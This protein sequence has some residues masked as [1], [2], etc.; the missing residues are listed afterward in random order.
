MSYP[1]KMLNPLK[2]ATSVVA[3]V[4]GAFLFISS[5]VAQNAQELE[6]FCKQGNMQ[7]CNNLYSS[8]QQACLNGNSNACEYAANM[9]RSFG[10]GEPQYPGAVQSPTAPYR[11]TIDNQR[12]YI[13]SK[14]SDPN[15]AMQLQAYGFCK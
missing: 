3:I 7:A 15:L 1:F 4:L 12:D 5:A 8:A 6:Y 9:A 10:R 11:G 14:C 13:N 2:L